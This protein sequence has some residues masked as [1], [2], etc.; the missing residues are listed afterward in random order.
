MFLDLIL[1][2]FVAPSW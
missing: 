1:F 2:N